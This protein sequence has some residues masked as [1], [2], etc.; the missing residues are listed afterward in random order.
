MAIDQSDFDLPVID[1][2]R[3]AYAPAYA[4]QS[5]EHQRVVAARES[6]A[7]RAGVLLLVEHDPPVITVTL[8]KGAPAHVLA[9]PDEL[10]AAGVEV[11]STDRGGDVT[12]HGPG[13]VVVYPILDLN[14]LELRLHDYIRLLEDVCMET[15][16]DF[17]L[18]TMRDATA[19]GV[20]T[21]APGPGGAPAP[22][23]KIAAIGVRIRRWITLHGVA[24]NV[25]PNLHHFDLIVPCGLAGRAVTS[26][27]RELGPTCPT[28]DAVKASLVRGF[29][30]ALSSR[31][32]SHRARQGPRSHAP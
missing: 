26:L 20:W 19:T 16:D 7:P 32:A 14:L 25:R 9:T 27:Q 11:C 29:R 10:R 3:M 18:P 13:Q 5:E 31:V 2:G 21:V 1:L 23:S 15:C 4:R 30:S 24:L 8:R 28:C 6:G 22:G 17:S 12:Y